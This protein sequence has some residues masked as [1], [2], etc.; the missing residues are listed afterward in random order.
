MR[1]VIPLLFH[2]AL[3]DEERSEADLRTVVCHFTRVLRAS[4]APPERVVVELKRLLADHPF[5]QQR[6]A[7]ALELQRR[8]ISACIR[9]FSGSDATTTSPTPPRGEPAA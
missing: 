3:Q 2:R 6:R 5:D 1:D 9:E 4:G 8:M 7:A